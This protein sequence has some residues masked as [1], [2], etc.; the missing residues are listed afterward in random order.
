MR[1]L[2]LVVAAF[3]LLAPVARA[4]ETVRVLKPKGVGVGRS[5]VESYEEL[6]RVALVQDGYKVVAGGKG[7]ADLTFKGTVTKVGTGL[8]LVL[9]KS[10]DDEEPYEDSLKIASEDELDVGTKRLVKSVLAGKPAA[11]SETVDDVTKAEAEAGTLRK[12]SVRHVLF[13][14]GPSWAYGL[15]SSDMLYDFALGY[16]WERD[17]L[18]PRVFVEAN[19]APGSSEMGSAH[20][21][22]G[23]DY[24]ILAGRTTPYVGA[25]VGLG[26]FSRAHSPENKADDNGRMYYSGFSF[27]ADLGIAIMRTS[28][29]SMFA[30]ASWRPLVG[31]ILGQGAG[32]YGGEIGILF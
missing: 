9:E 12:R 13:E 22:L 3:C 21:G 19:W 4:A 15:G 2:L 10:G 23:L 11:E 28:D 27:G 17:H 14:F 7:K 31:G 8:L 29:V 5:V 24:Y 20:A 6:I 1:A 32:I 16:V 30:Q 25:D 18:S 26:V